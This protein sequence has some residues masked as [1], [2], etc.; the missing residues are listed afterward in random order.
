MRRNDSQPSNFQKDWL[1]IEDFL[2]PSDNI[3][4]ESVMLSEPPPRLKPGGSDGCIAYLSPA[5]PM[6]RY[7]IRGLDMR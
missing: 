3:T 7:V 4:Y 5:L 6:Y 1:L 2:G